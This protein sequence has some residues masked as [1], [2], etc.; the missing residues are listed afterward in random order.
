MWIVGA[1]AAETNTSTLPNQ[2]WYLT[3][4][5]RLFPVFSRTAV[6][7]PQRTP[8]TG[9][10]LK[11][12]AGRDSSGQPQKYFTPNLSFKISPASPVS[13]KSS[14]CLSV[15]LTCQPQVQLFSCIFRPNTQTLEHLQLSRG[16][17]YRG[18]CIFLRTRLSTGWSPRRMCLASIGCVGCYAKL[19]GSWTNGRP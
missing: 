16:C 11:R 15:P 19:H 7:R 9:G 17:C 14:V 10:F 2:A 3:T 18:R 5:H 13:Q 1:L 12:E 6:C 8:D 4:R